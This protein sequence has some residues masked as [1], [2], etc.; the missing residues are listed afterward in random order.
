MM[1]KNVNIDPE[2]I[3]LVNDSI[4]Y[5]TS[6]LV[7]MENTRYHPKGNGT[8]VCLLKWLQKNQIPIQLQTEDKLQYIRA[9]LPFSSDNK[10]S[11]VAVEHPN[12]PGNVALYIKG[13][14]EIILAMCPHALV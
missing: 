11:A 10:F 8:E 13:A 12:R 5:N 3:Q 2:T 1:Q 9:S 14:P 7:E 6:A 4:I